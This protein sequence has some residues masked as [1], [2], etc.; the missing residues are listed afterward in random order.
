MTVK[1][2]N[3]FFIQDYGFSASDINWLQTVYP[4]VIALFMPILQRMG[5]P[6][7]LKLE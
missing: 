6:M 2:F 7:G 5:Q 4:L 3:L 1:F